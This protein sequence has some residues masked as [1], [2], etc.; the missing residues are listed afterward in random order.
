M[1]TFDEK[2]PTTT[3]ALLRQPLSL[4]RRTRPATPTKEPA[5]TEEALFGDLPDGAAGPALVLDIT[6]DLAAP[7]PLAAAAAA[8]PPARAEPRPPV[9]EPKAAPPPVTTP[10]P[11]QPSVVEIRAQ[12]APVAR[13]FAAWVAD[14]SLVAA[15]VVGLAAAAQAIVGR[16][17][18]GSL[19]VVAAPLGAL[20][21]LLFVLYGAASALLLR[22]NTLGLRLAGLALVDGSGQAPRPSKALARA[23]LSLVSAALLFAG[24]WLSLFDAAGQALHDKLTGTFVVEL[25]G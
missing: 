2:L 14:V 12:V 15:V 24:F 3:P 21:G 22:G 7:L 1:T 5:L 4:D 19:A 18:F 13:R 16:G 6:E 25:R 23:A 20:F 8:P 11:K 9:A 17:G 10:R